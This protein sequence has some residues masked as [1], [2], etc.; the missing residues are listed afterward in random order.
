MISYF[1][2]YSKKDPSK[3]IIAKIKSGTIEEAKLSFA[4]RKELPLSEFTKIFIVEAYE[5][6]NRTNKTNSSSPT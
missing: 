4:K 1:G 2:Y 5:D 3:E 6:T